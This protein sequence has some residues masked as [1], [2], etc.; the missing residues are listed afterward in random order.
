M[1][2]KTQQLEKIQQDWQIDATKHMARHKS[3]LKLRLLQTKENGS[4]ELGGYNLSQWQK[5][6]KQQG[7]ND[8]EIDQEYLKLKQEF[9]LIVKQF[10][11]APKLKPSEFFKILS[12]KQRNQSQND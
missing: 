1:D 6:L 5:N 10:L 8:E 7:K 4:L 12:N 3:G 2:T 9:S 11:P